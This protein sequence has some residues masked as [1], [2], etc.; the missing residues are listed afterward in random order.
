MHVYMVYCVCVCVDNSY[1]CVFGIQYMNTGPMLYTQGRLS[2]LI[3]HK[4]PFH[5]AKCGKTFN[6]NVQLV[7]HWHSHTGKKP[8]KAHLSIHLRIH[9][10]KKPYSGGECRR[11]F[12]KVSFLFQHQA[13][14]SGGRPFQCGM[15]GKALVRMST[16]VQHG[17]IHMGEKPYQCGQC[18]KAFWHQ[19]TL[20]AHRRVHT[21]ER[22]YKCKVCG[23]AFR[24]IGNLTCH[25]KTHAAAVVPAG[26][27]STGRRPPSQITATGEPEIRPETAAKFQPPIISLELT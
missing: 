15:C 20:M 18:G 2:S 19:P 14:H 8:Q 25:Q 5:C 13:I 21:W 26:E 11:S 3:L 22:P 6:Q 7:V 17:R 1:A 27:R 9:T 10:G 23:K 16:L 4:R 24:L 12:R